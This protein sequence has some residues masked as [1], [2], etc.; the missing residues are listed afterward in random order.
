MLSYRTPLKRG[1]TQRDPTVGY[2]IYCKVSAA[3]TVL[4]NEHIIPDGLGGDLI[5]QEASCLPCAKI[6][7]VFERQLILK[8]FG[9]LRTFLDIRSSKRRGTN[10]S[11][12]STHWQTE[13]PEDLVTDP[14]LHPVDGNM[15]AMA[16]L[17][18]TGK[19]ASILTNEDLGIDLP[20]FGEFYINN[21]D[22]WPKGRALTI[23][24][25]VGGTDLFFAKIAHGF[26]T[27]R[28]RKMAFEPY[29]SQYIIHDGWEQNSHLI[30]SVPRSA[31]RRGYLHKLRIRFKNRE[32]NP[33]AGG[34]LTPR[35]LV[36]VEIE[37]FANFSLPLVEVVAGEIPK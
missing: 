24:P 29:L 23:Q 37:L 21:R 6:I 30:G 14:M 5:F 1:I 10:K 35:T 33:I 18:L 20:R 3:E 31:I 27:S 19:R 17:D 11:A 32:C 9:Q 15:V 7:A 4:T 36:V 28:L 13:T 26:A 16:A 12:R 34:P 8:N 25:L 22:K 2:C